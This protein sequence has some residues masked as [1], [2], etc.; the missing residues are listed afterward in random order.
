LVAAARLFLR[1]HHLR[2]APKF[3]DS[4]DTEGVV[5]TAICEKMD[6]LLEV[7][8]DTTFFKYLAFLA[9]AELPFAYQTFWDWMVLKSG[10]MEYAESE[11]GQEIV[12]Q[13][14]RDVPRA[15]SDVQLFEKGITLPALT[16]EQGEQLFSSIR[17]PSS[18][19]ISG[20]FFNTE[21]SGWVTEELLVG[22]GRSSP[23]KSRRSSVLGSKKL[24]G[25]KEEL[26]ALV[27]FDGTE[28][29]AA[30]KVTELQKLGEKVQRNW[31]PELV[32]KDL[33]REFLLAVFQVLLT[34]ELKGESTYSQGHAVTVVRLLAKKYRDEGELL[35]NKPEPS[36]PLVTVENR[37]EFPDVVETM[38]ELRNTYAQVVGTN[39]LDLTEV[40]EV[41]WAAMR[42][43]CRATALR[44]HSRMGKKSD[45][46][47]KTLFGTT[48][49]KKSN[50]EANSNQL[51]QFLG[52]EPVN[53]FF[54]RQVLNPDVYATLVSEH[55][56]SET[57][58]RDSHGALLALGK[59]FS[60]P[61]MQFF[62]S[63]EGFAKFS[64]VAENFSFDVMDTAEPMQALQKLWYEKFEGTWLA[65]IPNLVDARAEKNQGSVRSR[66]PRFSIPSSR[67]RTR[68]Q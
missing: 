19:D 54:A 49:Q 41:V 15:D 1:L 4:S 65:T 55:L 10:D 44:K 21:R 6:R 56:L 24:Q 37:G 11:K 5:I 20:K 61:L 57:A 22:Q 51:F 60:V 46:V 48:Y 28:V 12:S 59:A 29:E 39:R 62:K 45:L 7:P 23:G 18:I 25:S 32:H 42:N 50:E 43:Q 14:W 64:K 40:Q 35:P 38:S 52:M 3:L 67:K 26:V 27:R 30:I 8:A 31:R 68:V 9:P 33:K 58:Q 53:G 13:I 16:Q 36:R 47:A 17:T 63:Q 2:K 34:V 66:K